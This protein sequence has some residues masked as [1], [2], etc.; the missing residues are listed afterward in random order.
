MIEGF[1]LL[2]PVVYAG[3]YPLDSQDFEVLRETL[4]KL[5]L[6]DSSL[7]YTPETSAALGFGFRCGFLGLLHM[8]IITERLAREYDQHIINTI[9]LDLEEEILNTRQELDAERAQLETRKAA[10]D[11]YRTRLDML[12][13]A[14]VAQHAIAFL[15]Q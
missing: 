14:E 3:I 7:D 4:S 12:R 10:V 1:R 5:K 13:E 11:K 9:Y 6:N 2:A 15:G 8:E